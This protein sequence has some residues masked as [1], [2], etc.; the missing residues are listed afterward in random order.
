[1]NSRDLER[2]RFTYRIPVESLDD[3]RKL[4][5][6]SQNHQL[7]IAAL[8]KAHEW[9]DVTEPELIKEPSK[10]Y[11]RWR[12]WLASTLLLVVYLLGAL[13]LPSGALLHMK[14]SGAYFRLQELSLQHPLWLWSVSSSDCKTNVDAV[15]DKAG[16]TRE[17]ADLICGIVQ[18][19]DVKSLIEEN[20]ATQR[21]L[22]AGALILL[23]SWFFSVT[24]QLGAARA[25]LALRRRTAVVNHCL[26]GK[27]VEP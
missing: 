17:E 22:F 25:A 20:Q 23:G 18:D 10:S 7:D 3:V 4:H 5:A 13:L 1:M 16:F 11:M 6:W 8:S 27:G 21:W 24:W 14:A 9:V 19:G 26:E 12:V 2:F 15:V